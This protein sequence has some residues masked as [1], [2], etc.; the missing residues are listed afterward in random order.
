MAT[1]LVVE[2]EDVLLENLSFHLSFEDYDV[3][4]AN[5][6]KKGVELA[7]EHIPDVIICDINMPEM[8]GYEVLQQIRS[9]SKTVSIPFIFL[10]ARSD[11]SDFRQ[12]MELGADDFITKP[13][14]AVEILS[15]IKSRLKKQGQLQKVHNEEIDQLRKNI[16]SNLPHE[17]KTPLSVILAYSEI[18][19][20]SYKDMNDEEI[21]DMISSINSSGK[22]LL[23][24]F[25]NY[26]FYTSLFDFKLENNIAYDLLT[27]F[28]EQE[29]RRVIS[30]IKKNYT[31]PYIINIIFEER[32]VPVFIS[33]FKKLAEEIID[34]AIKFS[35]DN[36]EIILKGYFL[37]NYY[38][39]ECQNSGIEFPQNKIDK[40]GGFMQFDREYLEQQGIGLGLAIVQ[41]IIHIYN[42]SISI[43]CSNRNTTVTIA[44]PILN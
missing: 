43:E 30:E 34:N 1:I 5:N 6:G 39:I 10:T 42:G 36:T 38:F 19:G 14:T 25:N 12:G 40:I 15:A 4:C 18:L 21:K 2:D 7:F 27:Q 28:P 9:N 22:R 20:R 11:K 33:H 17:L 24:M 35:D 37:N 41:K 26:T 23:R 13:Y 3:L 32:T 8:D 16:A 44:F 31:K 29:I